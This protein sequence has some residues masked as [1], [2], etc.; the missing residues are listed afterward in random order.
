MIGPLAKFIDWSALQ[1][2]YVGGLRHAPRP[3]WKLEEALGCL[4]GPDFIPVAS[5]PA[6]IEFDG[7]RHFKFPTP[8]P[9]EEQENNIVYGRLH[10]CAERWQERPV[11]ILLDGN[12]AIGYHTGF[13]LIARRFNWAG[14]NV[15]A[16]VAPHQLQ[17]RPRLPFEENCLWWARAIAQSVAEIRALTGWLLDEG[18]P[19]VALVGFSF[20]GWLAGL[21]ACSDPRITC[22]VLTVPGVR[23]RCC[24][25]VVWRRVRETFQSLRPAQDAMDATRLNLILSAPV[26][27]KENILLIEGIHDLFA[28]PPAI[29]ELWR[30]WQQPE[31]WRL[32]HG[33]VSGQLRLGLMGRVL[34]WLTPRLNAPAVRVQSFDRSKHE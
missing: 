23:M 19:S 18:C 11:I 21:T 6:R 27:P 26:I 28:D 20:G 32:P 8:R 10:R 30:K 17:R 15:A 24:Q 1:L 22:A 9:G 5:D 33:H 34:R 14:F 29:E 13:P 12:P 3:R 2:A 16:L 4:N 7:P 25:P 31:I